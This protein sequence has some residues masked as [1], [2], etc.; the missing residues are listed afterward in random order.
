MLRQRAE[1]KS[2]LLGGF[3]KSN[4]PWLV[5]VL[6]VLG[7][8][9]VIVDLEHGMIGLREC[10]ELVRAADATGILALIRVPDTDPVRILPLVETGPSGVVV[11]NVVGLEDVRK[12]SDAVRFSPLGRRGVGRSRAAAFG[13]K[14]SISDYISDVNA[15]MS[16]TAII[17][18]SEG[19]AH[20]AQI[21]GAPEVDMIMTGSVDM[22]SSLGVPGEV[23][24]PRV[25]QA[26]STIVAA[27][28]A[29]GKLTAG[30]ATSVLGLQ[31][32]LKEAELD[33]ICI[34]T[35]SMIVEHL[36][37]IRHLAAGS[38]GRDG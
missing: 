27:A 1:E 18:N 19:L 20:I 34:P 7:F 3:I 22:A 21:A 17:E 29:A 2:P 12:A 13:A 33:L 25:L 9:V 16:V 32:L 23:N 24:D 10:E 26:N 6:G 8:D 36:K 4:S 31:T 30:L 5:E 11:P 28:K 37:E 35:E 38:T 14:G 15:H